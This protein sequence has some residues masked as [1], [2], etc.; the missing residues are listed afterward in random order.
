MFMPCL[1][2]VSITDYRAGL[3][4]DDPVLYLPGT[5]VNHTGSTYSV[6]NA[7]LRGFPQPLT[8]R[9]SFHHSSNPHEIARHARI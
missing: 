7:K 6:T 9:A 3:H 1:P 5:Q 8:L 2:H 4:I